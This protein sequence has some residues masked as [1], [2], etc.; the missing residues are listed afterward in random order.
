MARL[1]ALEEA[2][3]PSKPKTKAQAKPKPLPPAKKVVPNASGSASSIPNFDDILNGE[4]EV[5]SFAGSGIDNALEMMSLV[6]E[7]TDKSSVGTAAAKIDAHPERRFK[8]AFEAYKD[9][10][11]PIIRKERPGMRLQQYHDALVRHFPAP[12]SPR[13]SPRSCI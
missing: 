13:P 1:T 7:R 3:M 2:S 5:N 4:E 12:P 9:E 10:Q 6:N 11:L 8:A